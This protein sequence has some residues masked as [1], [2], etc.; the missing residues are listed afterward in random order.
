MR[1]CVELEGVNFR[2]GDVQVLEDVNLT[3]APGDFLGLIGPNGSGKTTLL[4]IVLGLLAPTR[5][6]VRLFGKPP[7]TFR[8]WGRIGY[9]PQ[10]TTMDAALPVTVA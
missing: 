1:P 9:V 5:G 4:R 2:Y 7:A 6:S 10:R 3:V 8:E